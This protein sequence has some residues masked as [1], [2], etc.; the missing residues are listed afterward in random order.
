MLYPTTSPYYRTQIFN[1]Q[2][3][4][5]MVNRPVPGDPSD[6]YW[7]ITPTYNLRPDL[8]AYDLYKDGKLWWVFAQRNPN[9][10]KDPLFDFVSGVEIYIPKL[11]TLKTALSI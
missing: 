3:L 4:D 9:K 7:T 8:L 2:F 5:V 11:S 10:L 1:G 6:V